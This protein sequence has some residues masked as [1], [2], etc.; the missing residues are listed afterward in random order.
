MQAECR[1]PAQNQP[2]NR[3]FLILGMGVT[4]I[5][6]AHWF[7]LQGMAFDMA[8]S[9][10]ILS[11]EDSLR[12]AFPASALYLGE[13]E[14]LLAETYQA[15]VISPGVPHDIPLVQNLRQQ[16]LKLIGDIDLFAAVSS[17]PVTAVTGSNGKSTVV[18]MLHHMYQQAGVAS[19]LGGNFGTPVLDLLGDPSIKR[20]IL[21]LSSFQLDTA[22]VFEADVAALLNV[23]EDHMDRYASFESY[24]AS[25]GRIYRNA[26]VAV[27]NRGDG[28]S[29]RLATEVPTTISFGQDVPA[30]GQY[31]CI[32]AED[33]TWLCR[34]D[35]KLLPVSA[36]KVLGRHNSVNALAAL[37][38]GE[39]AGLDMSDMLA[40]L[41]SYQGLPHRTEWISKISGVTWVNDS[42]ATNVGA[43]TAALKGINADVILLA[44][45]RGKDADF[46]PLQAVAKQYVKTAIIFGEDRQRLSATLV[47]CTAVE[48]VETLEQAV[49]KASKIAVSGD[50]VLLSPAC[51]SFDQFPA[52]T[53][54]GE[55][56]R[57]LVVAMQGGQ[58]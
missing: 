58:S 26:R 23:S 36:L 39:A 22:E 57:E 42:K 13:C 7:S 20:F 12:E 48:V 35:E 50:I 44:G 17:V 24:A 53:V 52:Y 41:E 34:G 5:S 51:S 37:A 27:V 40:A 47:G 8:D 28:W 31:G 43:V 15:V 54:R 33:E 32:E 14:N 55:R 19:A 45:G 11:N 56:F 38:L 21:E 46:Q 9:R 1:I 30:S 29:R 4:G 25:K 6:V 10:S 16:Q 49:A 3:P 2:D 18:D